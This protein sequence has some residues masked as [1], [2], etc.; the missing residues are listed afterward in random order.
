MAFPLTP[1]KIRGP[2]FQ[3][4][5]GRTVR[6]TVSAEPKITE[7]A[8]QI[9]VK[10]IDSERELRYRAWVE[11]NRAYVDKRTD[12]KVGYIYV[13]DT[14]VLGQN[15]LVRQFVGQLDKQ[16]LIIDERWNGEEQIP[17]RF[18]E[19]LNRPVANYWA[20]R[21]KGENM[22]WPPD[23]QHGP[24]SMLI[25]GEAGSGG[26]Y[27]PYWFRKAGVGKLIGRRTW[28]GLIG[29]SGNPGLIDGQSVTVPRFAFYENDGTWGVEGNGVEPDIEVI[30][31]PA[32]MVG[33]KDPQLDAGID[34]MLRGIAEHP[35]RSV[36][37]PPYPDRSGMGIT[38]ENK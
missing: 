29:M 27:F 9:L 18:V 1:P 4:M 8:R 2:P 25:N 26:D 38:E 13:P 31:D 19:L 3:G 34:L 35:Y 11:K 36:P 12:G 7:K 28:G 17:T 14:G 6:L 10:L 21:T 20:A 5:A 24:K 33:G 32:L 30:D 22:A 37:R 15:E 16:A 23:A